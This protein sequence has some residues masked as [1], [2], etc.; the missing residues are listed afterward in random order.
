[1]V[2]Y[3]HLLLV[4]VSPQSGS[5]GNQTIGGLVVVVVV[6]GFFFFFEDEA[7]EAIL[8]G[9]G[10]GL[11]L[12]G[13]DDPDAAYLETRLLNPSGARICGGKWCGLILET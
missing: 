5:P 7:A 10:D 8:M 13:V 3:D 4:G 6:F 9:A 12:D 11:R 1:M 2:F